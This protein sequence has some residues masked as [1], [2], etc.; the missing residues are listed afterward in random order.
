MNKSLPCSGY[1]SFRK[2]FVVFVLRN[3]STKFLCTNS[4][5][6][7]AAVNKPASPHGLYTLY[8]CARAYRCHGLSIE[9]E[10]YFK[11]VSRT[12]GLSSPHRKLAKFVPPVSIKQA[13][14]QVEAAISK[15][16][17][18]G[19]RQEYRRFRLS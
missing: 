10:Q 7:V 5:Q 6:S 3:L 15:T 13:N 12:P 9:M 16:S 19:K 14:K 1:I 17:L 4:T 18:K 11:P 8:A 2:I